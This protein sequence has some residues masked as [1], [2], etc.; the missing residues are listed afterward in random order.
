[1]KAY[2]YDKNGLY[3]GASEANKNP[4]NPGEYLLPAMATFIEPPS[5]ERD[6]A[7]RFNGKTW[8]LI[9]DYSRYIYYKKETK[10]V[11]RYYPGEEPD[12]DVYTNIEPVGDVDQFIDGEWVLSEK[13]IKEREIIEARRYLAETDWYVI[14][15]VEPN[16]GDPI[17]EEV[18]T[19]RSEAL[20]I[21]NGA[22]NLSEK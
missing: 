19:K 11:K 5:I 9:P 22:V 17:P 21:I 3:T 16:R 15:F 4:M 14:R 20:I 7:I 1:M 10:E 6:R 2:N 18:K 13:T 12:L 8:E